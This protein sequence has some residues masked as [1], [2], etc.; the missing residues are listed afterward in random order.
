MIRLFLII[1]LLGIASGC[2]KKT[3]P[4]TGPTAR[5]GAE[6][7]VVAIPGKPTLVFS[8]PK[9]ADVVKAAGADAEGK[10][11]VIG[12]VKITLPDKDGGRA[13]YDLDY[14][15]SQP[16]AGNKIFRCHIVAAS[17]EI[18]S[19]DI[20]PQAGKGGHVTD[21]NVVSFEFKP[22]FTVKVDEI[23]FL[24]GRNGAVQ[25]SNAFEIR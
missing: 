25:V 8:S 17:G 23:D 3:T 11:V 14:F 9:V 21:Y 16:P 12:N 20:P 7:P 10:K 22:P 2:G 24:T 15:V 1:C 5:P 4:T 13:Q 19:V 18:G 6:P